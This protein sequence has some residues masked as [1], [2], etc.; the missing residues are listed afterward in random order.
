[1]I[2][3]LILV[4]IAIGLVAS[5]GYS[6]FYVYNSFN[7]LSEVTLNEL[8][9]TRAVLELEKILI[10]DTV[11]NLGKLP[12]AGEMFTYKINLD[13]GEV[14]NNESNDDRYYVLPSKFFPLAYNVNTVRYP[15]CPFVY[16]DGVISTP[17]E[18]G[19]HLKYNKSGANYLLDASESDQTQ[20]LEG[21]RGDLNVPYV[22]ETS[23][24][25]SY[26]GA[27]DVVNNSIVAFVIIPNKSITLNS[28]SSLSESELPFCQN[29]TYNSSSEIFEVPNGKVKVVYDIIK[30][31]DFFSLANNNDGAVILGNNETGN[32]ISGASDAE[33]SSDAEEFYNTESTLNYYTTLYGSNSVETIVY[34]LGNGNHYLN[35][36]TSKLYGKYYKNKLTG[37]RKR[38]IIFQGNGKRSGSSGTKIIPYQWTSNGIENNFNIELK[39]IEVEFRNLTIE[40]MGIKLLPNSKLELQGVEAPW[41]ESYG[42]SIVIKAYEK[43]GSNNDVGTEI[44]PNE[45]ISGSL[46]RTS[47]AIK[48]YDSKMEVYGSSDLENSTYDLSVGYISGAGNYNISLD[49]SQLLFSSS[50]IYINSNNNLPFYIINKSVLNNHL[51]LVETDSVNISTPYFYVDSGSDFYLNGLSSNNSLYGY[52]LSNKGFSS[53]QPIIYFNGNNLNINNSF[54]DLMFQT[55]TVIS[56]YNG[57]FQIN[58]SNFGGTFEFSNSAIID[59]GIS[60]LSGGTSNFYGDVASNCFSGGVFSNTTNNSSDNT[61]SISGAIDTFEEMLYVRNRSNWSCVK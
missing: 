55:D 20:I 56:G 60:S 43:D 3:L 6:L 32:G 4:F 26:A 8:N 22:I 44:H 54:I 25:A 45:F 10:D 34:N 53:S 21:T 16:E 24:Q 58:N 5:L 38:K 30:S 39:D 40:D 15:Y 14:I 23:N 51:S 33:I 57:S 47:P 61:T 2:G 36:N 46:T 17:T 7:T 13:D 12:I 52:D 41:I 1:M 11:N 18:N 37:D 50:N 28:L 31:S 49:N 48:L 19:L 59:N 35:V 9:S 42:S 29:V 27:D